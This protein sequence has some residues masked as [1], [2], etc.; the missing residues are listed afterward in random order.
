MPIPLILPPA[1]LALAS[2]HADR[3]A[4]LTPQLAP[5]IEDLHGP[6]LRAWRGLEVVAA[7]IEDALALRLE[8]LA[9][10]HLYD[11]PDWADPASVARFRAE[12]LSSL[13]AATWVGAGPST[14]ERIKEA[15]KRQGYA[16]GE[17][18]LRIDAALADG[19]VTRQIVERVTLYR[20]DPPT[21]AILSATELP[22]NLV[23][24]HLPAARDARV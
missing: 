4:P 7:G 12:A 22:T 24:S 1:D 8:R 11:P 18:R 10:L 23:S 15:A 14:W 13:L 21:G 16:P 2:E 19:L 3:L 5:D 9:V 17:A 20:L 6:G